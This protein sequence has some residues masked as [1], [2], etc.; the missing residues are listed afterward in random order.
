MEAG[1]GDVAE[2][3]KKEAF[4]PREKMLGEPVVTS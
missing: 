2:E 4:G 3:G 1:S